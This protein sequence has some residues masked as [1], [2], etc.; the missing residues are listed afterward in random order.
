V[1]EQHRSLD[2]MP[3]QMSPLWYANYLDKVLHEPFGDPSGRREAG[4]VLKRLFAL[5][6]SKFEPS[7]L[8]AIGE[9]EQRRTAK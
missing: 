7:P 3:W 8:Q 4:E 1:L 2:L 6:L 5:G 9:A